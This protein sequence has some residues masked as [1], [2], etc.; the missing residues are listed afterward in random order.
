MLSVV[1]G[2]KVIGSLAK[3]NEP[4]VG[5]IKSGAAVS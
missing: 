1:N 4:G 2:L 5:F 3:A